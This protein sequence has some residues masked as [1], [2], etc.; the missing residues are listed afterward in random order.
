M[1]WKREGWSSLPQLIQSSSTRLEPV[2]QLWLCLHRPGIHGLLRQL[3][4]VTETMGRA[5]SQPPAKP[6]LSAKVEVFLMACKFRAKNFWCGLTSCSGDLESHPWSTAA[7]VSHSIPPVLRSR[8]LSARDANE[9][10]TAERHG[11]ASRGMSRPGWGDG[12]GD[13]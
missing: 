1:G 9:P 13:G 7:R 5:R 10:A 11:A 4:K 2:L 8:F 3:Q 6:C 12:L